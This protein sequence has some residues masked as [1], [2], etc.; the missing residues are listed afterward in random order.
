M[1]TYTLRV[2]GMHCPSCGLLI[3]DALEDVPGVISAQTR[4]REARTTVQVDPDRCSL[5]QILTAVAEAGYA[6]EVV[7][8]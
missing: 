2:D 8:Q 4:M 7:Q 6:A 3:D 1:I 5:A